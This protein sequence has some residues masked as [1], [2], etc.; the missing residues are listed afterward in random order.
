MNDQSQSEGENERGPTTES[1]DGVAREAIEAGGDDGES[2]ADTV[3]EGEDE[4]A[5]AEL[6]RDSIFD[7]LVN[8]RRRLVLRYLAEHGGP[9]RLG[10]LA[11]HVAAIENDL[12]ADALD[13]AQR[14]RVYISL[15]QSHLPRLDDMGIIEFDRSHGRVEV[16]PAAPQVEKYL[17]VEEDG[18]HQWYRYHVAFTAICTLAVLAGIVS[19]V[20][21]TATGALLV[22]VGTSVAFMVAV[23]ALDH[24]N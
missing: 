11:E 5:S 22:V 23:L 19:G 7:A 13:S 6:P 3:L 1:G 2:E 20:V 21:G 17:F 4:K 24:A 10:D 9:V 8:S 15:Y 16:G 14:Q 12:S 18:G